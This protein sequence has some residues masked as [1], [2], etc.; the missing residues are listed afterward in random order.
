MPCWRISLSTTS[1][2]RSSGHSFEGTFAPGQTATQPCGL[3][4]SPR[5][6][7]HV[8]AAS[9]SV[10][11]IRKSMQPSPGAG[12]ATPSCLNR[13][14]RASA[15]CTWRTGIPL[16]WRPASPKKPLVASRR[17]TPARRKNA[18]SRKRCLGER[19]LGTRYTRVRKPRFRSWT[20]PR[21]AARIPRTEAPAG[22]FSK[23]ST[24]PVA[25][26]TVSGGRWL[27]LAGISLSST[28]SD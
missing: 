22:Y 4:G 16:A 20:R 7:H 1:A 2:Y 14:S 9:R 26:R 17:F 27:L 11:V 12:T 25:G 19:S 15:S 3:V 28:I 6:N 23:L 13:A 5:V 21:R 18:P 24:R 8:R 10:W